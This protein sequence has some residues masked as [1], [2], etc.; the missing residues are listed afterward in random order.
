MEALRDEIVQAVSENQWL[1][2]HF[3]EAFHVEGFR[4]QYLPVEYEKAKRV[5]TRSRSD[6]YK[7]KLHHA[8]LNVKPQPTEENNPFLA[9]KKIVLDSPRNGK[10]HFFL[11]P[12]ANGGNLES[13]WQGEA[14]LDKRSP[15][16]LYWVVKQMTGIVGAV[17]EIHFPTETAAED[18]GYFH[19]ALNPNNIVLFIE[20]SKENPRG[21]LRITDTGLD[22]FYRKITSRWT[23]SHETDKTLIAYGPPRPRRAH[24]RDNGSPYYDMWSLGCL[25]LEFVVWVLGGMDEV[26]K[27]RAGREKS[28]SHRGFYQK[29]IFGYNI[30]PEVRRYIDLILNDKRCQGNNLL[31]DVINIIKNRLLRTRKNKRITSAEL[32]PL[33]LCILE[34]AKASPSYLCGP[35][36]ES[37]FY[38]QPIGYPGDLTVTTVDRLIAK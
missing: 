35:D 15:E 14:N 29:T 20:D 11:F 18:E 36:S 28:C 26:N 32:E 27:F 16:M 21:V 3:L 33:L 25:F 22:R 19:G 17:K 9:M 37:G 4:D 7:V 30:Q 10:D 34:K 31:R 12:W 1:N 38:P 8:H 23:R 6:V 13:V 5:F 24:D 2:S